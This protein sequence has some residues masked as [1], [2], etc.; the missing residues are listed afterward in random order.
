[1]DTA[2][3]RNAYGVEPALLKAM[4]VG[5][6]G[7]S[8]RLSDDGFGSCGYSQALPSIRA[9]CGI[10]G[11]ASQSCAAI[12]NDIQLDMNC[13][14]KLIKD[15]GGRCGM[16]ARGAASCYNSGVPNNC[17][18]TTNRYCDRVQG[19]YNGCK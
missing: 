7:C 11:S 4:I 16:D 19:Y 2:I 14:A 10:P 17:A 1:M 13:T 15:N 6:E 3:R 8:K 9:W 5:G 18:R 12:Q